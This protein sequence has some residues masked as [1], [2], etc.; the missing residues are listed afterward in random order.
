MEKWCLASFY[1]NTGEMT[2]ILKELGINPIE[3][4]AMV[5][6]YLNNENKIN[7]EYQFE[8][9]LFKNVNVVYESMEYCINGINIWKSEWINTKEFVIIRDPNYHQYFTFQ[10]YTLK[11]DKNNTRF[12]A[13][14]FSNAVY[15]IYTM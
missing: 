14:E 13:G 15:G 11:D 9:N 7:E 4:D 8:S 1:K 6:N 10:V 12:A 2:A 3:V 5:N